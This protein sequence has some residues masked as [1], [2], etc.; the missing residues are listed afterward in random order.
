MLVG[1]SIIIVLSLRKKSK[2]ELWENVVYITSWDFGKITLVA[3]CYLLIVLLSIRYTTVIL[4]AILNDELTWYEYFTTY[5]DSF[6]A[7]V[8]ALALFVL[9]L[10]FMDS[11]ERQT[12]TIKKLEEERIQHEKQIAETRLINNLEKQLEFYSK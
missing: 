10:Q 3:L 1:L 4:S 7:F 6:G 5:G 8:S 2:S 11:I 9:V 12:D